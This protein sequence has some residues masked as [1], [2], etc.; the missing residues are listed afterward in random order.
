MPI[1]QWELNE[2]LYDVANLR[3]DCV[4]T[5]RFPEV[6]TIIAEECERLEC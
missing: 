6:L 2:F 4:I 1:D 5:P 3:A